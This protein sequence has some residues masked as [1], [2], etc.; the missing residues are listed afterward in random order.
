MATLPRLIAVLA[1]AVCAAAGDAPPSTV[2]STQIQPL[3]SKH[4]WSCHG[5]DK[6]KGNLRLDSP[7]AI[8]Q[9]G[10]KGMAVVAG[11]PEKS[12]LLALTTLPADDPDVM[13][14]KGDHLTPAQ[15]DL[16][17]TWIVAGADFGAGPTTV[18]KAAPYVRPTTTLDQRAA[19]VTPPGEAALKKLRDLGA[20]V[21]AV[22]ANQALIDV[23]LRHATKLDEALA[24]T[25][26]VAT[27]VVWLDLGGSPFT[28]SQAK[29]I[30]RL[31]NLSRLHL[32]RT[33]CGDAVLAQLA[34]C[35]QLEYLNCYG[36]KI[37]DAGLK[38]LA[39]LKTLRAL[40]L[41]KTAVTTA[42]I[43]TLKQALPDLVVTGAPPESLTN[44]APDETAGKKKGKKAK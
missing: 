5:A 35:P 8:M 19:K 43:A 29:T 42:G 17:R 37:T 6:Q 1:I 7:S 3:L 13:P 40:Y 14:Q 33:T 10:K 31:T 18:A 27:N 4:C 41:W 24:A 15:I 30:G 25:E 22:S 9:G 2:Y 20:V 21:T 23:N 26:A 38:S 32:E 44:P 11:H 36:T 34:N 39:A 12:S 16:L 28:D